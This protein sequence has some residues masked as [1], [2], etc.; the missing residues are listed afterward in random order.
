M[1][2]T[3]VAEFGQHRNVPILARGNFPK[4]EVA[5]DPLVFP[6]TLLAPSLWPAVR[7]PHPSGSHNIV[8][9]H[10]REDHG[11]LYSFRHREEDPFGRYRFHQCGEGAHLLEVRL[12]ETSLSQFPA[13]RSR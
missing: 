7:R 6:L 4:W 5:Q 3:D 9:P 8:R 11:G 10:T 2:A 13:R 1:T 12:P